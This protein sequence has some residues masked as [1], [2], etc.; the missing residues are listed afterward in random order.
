MHEIVKKIVE[1]NTPPSQE[2]NTY[3]IN[4]SCHKSTRTILYSNHGSL[5]HILVIINEM[6]RPQKYQGTGSF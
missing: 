3:K 5:S 6:D 2:F 4:S 1:I